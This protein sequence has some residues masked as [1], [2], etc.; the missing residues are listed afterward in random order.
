MAA[1]GG[2]GGQRLGRD[3]DRC[4]PGVRQFA[5]GLWRKCTNRH[6]VRHTKCRTGTVG[7]GALGRQVAR[8][9][10]QGHRQTQVCPWGAADYS[11]WQAHDPP[12]GVA[13][14]DVCASGQGRCYCPP[15]GD[16]HTGSAIRSGWAVII[17]CWRSSLGGRGRGLAVQLVQARPPHGLPDAVNPL[18]LRHPLRLS[19]QHRLQ[20]A[21]GMDERLQRTCGLM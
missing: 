5:R 19:R 16:Q 18:L 7:A 8:L 3:P 21:V 12:W 4:C 2:S 11:S 20:V 13:T 10:G 9:A 6:P 1:R 17:A 14:F 15:A